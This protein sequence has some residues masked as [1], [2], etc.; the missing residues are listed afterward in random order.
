MKHRAQQNDETHAWWKTITAAEL[1]DLRRRVVDRLAHRCLGNPHDLEDAAQ[2]ALVAL[3]QNRD[4]VDA[5]S[6]GLLR[7]TYVVARNRLLDRKKRPRTVALQDE[8]VADAG[9]ISQP[10]SQ[11]QLAKISS[12]LYELDPLDR[13]L[14]WRHA[15]DKGSVNQ[16]AAETGLYWHKAANR[17]SAAVHQLSRRLNESGLL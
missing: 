6:H 12:F 5:A 17:I 1:R 10:E 11:E 15:V 7:Y 2:D 3:F 13:Y 4:S 14:L 16:V 9:A 8:H